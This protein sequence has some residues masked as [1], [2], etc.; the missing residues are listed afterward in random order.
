METFSALL[1]LCAGNS[2]VTSQF[3]TQKPVRIFDIFFEMLFNKRLSKQSWGWWFETTT[4]S[5]CRHCNDSCSGVDKCTATKIM[6]W[7]YFSMYKNT[8]PWQHRSR[9]YSIR[10]TKYFIFRNSCDTHISTI[11]YTSHYITGEIWNGSSDI[12]AS[13]ATFCRCCV[14]IIWWG[15]AFTAYTANYIYIYIYVCVCV[16]AWMHYILWWI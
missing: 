10:H 1:T 8:Y 15:D 6:W 12:W 16:Y 7:N 4:C 5:L 2:P 13:C 9:L 3:P 14:F 11:R